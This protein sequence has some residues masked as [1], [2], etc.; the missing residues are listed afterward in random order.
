VA[1]CFYLPGYVVR[2]LLIICKKHSTT[3]GLF[4]WDVLG[5]ILGD[6]LGLIQNEFPLFVDLYGIF[7]LLGE[8]SLPL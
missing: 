1:N 4:L 5:L 6:A 8:M 2:E 3:L 7:N